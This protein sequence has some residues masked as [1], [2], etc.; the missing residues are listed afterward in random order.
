MAVP[1]SQRKQVIFTR[2]GELNARLEQVNQ[3][4]LFGIVFRLDIE[5]RIAQ[6]FF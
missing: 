5:V 1:I 6:H 2:A 3:P 4:L